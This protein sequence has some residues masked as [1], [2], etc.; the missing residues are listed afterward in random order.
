MQKSNLGELKCEDVHAVNWP[1][2]GSIAAVL[3]T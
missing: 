3:W 1:K 2:V